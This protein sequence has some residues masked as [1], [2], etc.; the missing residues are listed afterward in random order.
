MDGYCKPKKMKGYADGGM[1][2]PDM[3]GAYTPDRRAELYAE[4][5]KRQNGM[6]VGAGN[7]LSSVG[8]AIA[9]GYGGDRG[10]NF[11][12]KS[13][14]IQR[15]GTEGGL[16]LIDQ[17]ISDQNTTEMNNPA[18][19]RSR[20][21]QQAAAPILK[22]AG[23]DDSAIGG[24]PASYIDSI[25]K[26]AT[27]FSDAQARVQATLENSRE[28]R[29]LR[30]DAMDA[31]K[32]EDMKMREVPGFVNSGRVA[33][34]SNEAAKLRDGVT[35]F[36]TFLD[37]L[38]DYQKYVE[39]YGTGEF[40]NSGASGAMEQLATSLQL[41]IKKLAQLGVLSKSDEPFIKKQIPDPGFFQREGVMKS[42]LATSEREFKRDVINQLRARGYE[43]DEEMAARLAGNDEA[44]VGGG[45]PAAAPQV[46]GSFQG[47]KIIKVTK[48]K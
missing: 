43:P 26:H 8:D 2:L 20:A 45:A 32:T 34:N 38:H 5:M 11:L 6:G 29:Q 7:A 28:N 44:L 39:N 42:T 33:V 23:L 48:L 9:R 37:K 15:T 47:K 46:G 22:A 19:P 21:L 1:V 18:S 24:I 35:A 27:D 12:D 13:M 31:K 4:L 14:G 3:S 41:D 30:S 36:N 17:Q 16:K 40:M 25:L 10:A